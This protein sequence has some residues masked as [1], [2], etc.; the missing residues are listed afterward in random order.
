MAGN[1][2]DVFFPTTSVEALTRGDL[3][4]LLPTGLLA[5]R[6]RHATRMRFRALGVEQASDMGSEFVAEE[7][8]S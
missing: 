1:L 6:C 8:L 2:L 4:L 7:A 5:G 3:S